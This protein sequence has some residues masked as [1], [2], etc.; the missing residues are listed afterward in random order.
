[1]TAQ[2]CPRCG[3]PAAAAARFCRACGAPLTASPEPAPAPDPA[4]PAPPAP[5]PVA[6]PEPVAAPG[7]KW[8]DALA[9]ARAWWNRRPRGRTPL[10][11]G[12]GV[13][14]VVVLALVGYLAVV[15]INNARYPPDQP[16]R[17]LFAALTARDAGAAA[18]LAACTTAACTGA[19]LAAG[20]EPPT[21][22]EIGE[23]TYG[24]PTDDT[25]RPDKS[26]ASVPVKYRLGGVPQTVTMRVQRTGD[27]LARPFRILTGATGHLAVTAGHLKQVQLGGARVPVDEQGL[28]AL[29]G[30]Y[31]VQVPDT[32]PLFA[33]TPA[34]PA[35]VDV[36]AT[37]DPRATPTALQLPVQ[38]RPQVV[39]Q[40]DEQV[41]AF[42]DA[43][44]EQE[45]LTPRG[46]PFRVPGIVIGADNVRWTVER[47]PVIQVVPVDEPS[48]TDPPAAVETVESGRVRVT[49]TAFTSAGGSRSTLTEQ[50]PIEITGTVDIDPVKPGQVIWTG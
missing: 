11:A 31:T 42:L 27:G 10:L 23:I 7:H 39:D 29:P 12:G 32:D 5:A 43:C 30:R 38:I 45:T 48:P 20:Y 41:A 24:D 25:R 15:A 37:S 21:D 3:A 46:C 1:V 19:A 13:A 49:Y 22:V 9:P 4:P 8:A 18:E 47:P 50:L 34:A 28:T 14:L 36:T 40:V 35:R 26:L 16:V 2:A 17:A 6:V 33:P 44:A